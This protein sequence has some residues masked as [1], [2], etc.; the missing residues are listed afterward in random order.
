MSRLE[1]TELLIGSENLQKLKNSHVAVFGI[2]G[3]GCYAAEGLARAG[4]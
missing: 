4:I 1:R 2:G 3:V